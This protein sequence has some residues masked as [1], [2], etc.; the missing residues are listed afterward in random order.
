MDFGDLKVIR[1]SDKRGANGTR[2][3][4][5]RCKC[6]EV[7]YVL[8]A[9]LRAGYYKSCGCNRE[10]KRDIGAR[11]HEKTDRVDGTRKTALKAKLHKGN[12]S[13]HKGV[14]WNESRQKWTA[15]I[16]FKGKQISLGYFSEKEDAIKARK[17]AEE[18]YFDPIL[19][20]D[21]EYKG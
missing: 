12:K 15:H 11:E 14:R 1:L 19:N 3:W 6:G 2:L 7:I 17:R 13:G 4:E 10:E 21:T 16:G 20:S 9:S 18:K 8:G 5:C